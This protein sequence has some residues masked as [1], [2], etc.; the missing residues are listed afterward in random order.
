MLPRIAFHS[1]HDDWQKRRF[2]TIQTKETKETNLS[3]LM[4]SDVFC[5]LSSVCCLLSLL[6]RLLQ[7]LP[8]PGK[9]RET[10]RISQAH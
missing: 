10:V 5:L 3:L 6:R 9:P 8:L 7:Q 2:G 4:S 1:A